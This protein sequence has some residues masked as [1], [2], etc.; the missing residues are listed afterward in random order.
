MFEFLATAVNPATN[1]VLA[2]TGIVGL[3]GISV[4]LY[5][6]LTTVQQAQKCPRCGWPM[7]DCGW[8][9][10][11]SGAVDK[12]TNERYQPIAVRIH[13]CAKC[14]VEHHEKI[15]KPEIKVGLYSY[16]PKIIKSNDSKHLAEYAKMPVNYKRLHQQEYE[17]IVN[18]AHKLINE[19]NTKYNS[20]VKAN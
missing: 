7:H 14:K 9:E 16:D 8:L 5:R 10:L 18:T 11:F 19:A 1:F 3:V 13:Q 2:A 15:N 20:Y 12:N 4:S 6:S 17:N